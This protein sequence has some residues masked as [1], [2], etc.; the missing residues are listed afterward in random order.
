[1]PMDTE[2]KAYKLKILCKLFATNHI[3]MYSLSSPTVCCLPTSSVRWH[4]ISFSYF[5]PQ[6]CLCPPHLCCSIKRC[7]HTESR[8]DLTVC[9]MDDTET[10]NPKNAGLLCNSSDM[11]KSKSNNQ[12]L[13]I[14]SGNFIRLLHL[15][16]SHHIDSDREV[17]YRSLT[18]EGHL[19]NFCWFHTLQICASN[20]VKPAKLSSNPREN[21][22]LLLS[23]LFFFP[24]K[25][26]VF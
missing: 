3:N 21:C 8:R 2:V 15:E 4:T 25:T 18:E 1:M 12:G 10:G 9:N 17:S 23:F 7:G 19:L 22:G 16:V 5:A 20:T 13:L 24:L 14:H 26:E 6:R 11:A